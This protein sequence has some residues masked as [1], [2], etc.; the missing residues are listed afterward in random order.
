MKLTLLWQLH[1]M[2]IFRPALLHG[3]VSICALFHF[4][5]DPH[6]NVYFSALDGSFVTP[7]YQPASYHE[8]SMV[9]SLLVLLY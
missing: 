5:Y 1:P 7:I 6:F 2:L 4:H 3:R 8:Y 9:W